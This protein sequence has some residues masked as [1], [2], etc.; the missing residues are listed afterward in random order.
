MPDQ[1][2]LIFDLDGTLIDT[3]TQLADLFCE[4]LQREH[5]VP[6]DVSRPIYVELAGKG[7]RPQFEAVLATI[8]Q[9]DQELVD[10][11]T[12]RYWQVAETFEPIAFPETL[13]VLKQLHRDG[14][15]LAV[16]SGGTTASVERKTRLTG[17]G[18]LFSLALGTDEGVPNMR[19]GPG[20][21]ELL[22][23]GLDLTEA[24]LQAR[25]VFV[26]DAVF[27]MQ[28]ARDARIVAVGRVSDGNGEAMRRAGA[29]HLIHDLREMHALLPAL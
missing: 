20:H 11:I 16:S 23:S 14:H 10:G 13:D 17:I 15:T 25:G 22:R 4:M 18:H 28:V 8:G 9:H 3:M 1:R 21:F 7:P 24:D 2:I 26:G 5:G 6:A 29:Q 27:D 19:K 12:E